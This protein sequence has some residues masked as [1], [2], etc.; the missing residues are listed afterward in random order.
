MPD[1]DGSLS[2]FPASIDHFVIKKPFDANKS[3]SQQEQHALEQA[4]HFN[5]MFDSIVNME[6]YMLTGSGGAG[7]SI[8]TR[9]SSGISGSDQD[10]YGENL[11]LGYTTLAISLTGN[12]ISVTSLVPSTFGESPF[13]KKGFA[14][15]HNLYVSNPNGNDATEGIWS[16]TTWGENGPFN[17]TIKWFQ[18]YTMIRP[19]TGSIFEVT[20]TNLPIHSTSNTIDSTFVEGNS[21]P[22]NQQWQEFWL[23]S[24]WTGTGLRGLVS[25]NGGVPGSTFWRGYCESSNDSRYGW[26]WPTMLG[27]LTD[28]HVEWGEIH[29][30]FGTPETSDECYT[31]I[32][33]MVRASGPIDNA[34][35]YCVAIGDI[36]TNA[37]ALSLD[38]GKYG[39]IIKVTGANLSNQ[40]PANPGGG[41]ITWGGSPTITYIGTGVGSS[42]YHWFGQTGTRFRLVCESV[43]G[44]AKITVQQAASPFVSWSTLYGPFFDGNSPIASGYSGFFAQA[45]NGEDN[46]WV[47]FLGSVKVTNLLSSSSISTELQLMFVLA[48]PESNLTMESGS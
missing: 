12:T 20:L 44:S 48:G 34:S 22:S 35:F 25:Q 41:G 33:P 39:R 9:W 19:V 10:A 8:V 36:P 27:V 46:R 32:G 2:S 28:S 30:R 7:G 21:I 47:E 13:D 18:L 43:P 16:N 31:R 6:T 14:I 15:A 37:G 1:R 29:A 38:K 5:H 45:M 4:S 23:R 42:G 3:L 11:K 40:G 26:A 24:G 17:E